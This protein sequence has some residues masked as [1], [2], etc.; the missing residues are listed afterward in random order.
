MTFLEL[1]NDA[2]DRLNLPADASGASRDRIKRYINE[3]YRWLLADVGM[4]RALDSTATITT[5]ADTAEYTVTTGAI[6]AIR[7]LVSDT[8]LQE[9]T[10]VE[11]RRRDPGD[12]E[13]GDPTHYAIRNAGATTL[14]VRLWPTPVDARTLQLDVTA[15][16]TDLSA[17]GDVPV[18][19]AE[20]HHALSIY[21][22]MCEYEK[23]DDT[24]YKEASQLWQVTIRALRFALRRS[25]S[26]VM[27]QGRGP[28]ARWS[29]FGSNF[30]EPQ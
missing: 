10:L 20:Y 23:M 26:R 22:R 4:S 21:A 3:G 27:T 9:A 25:D 8:V 6:R 28:I 1:Q 19:K 13:T 5:V 12:E 18:F 29:H 11:L 17:D 2:L 24:R 7:D 30:P 16:V 15:T 14:L